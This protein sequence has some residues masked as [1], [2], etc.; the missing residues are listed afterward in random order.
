[1]FAQSRFR[2]LSAFL[3]V[4]ALGACATAAPPPPPNASGVPIADRG[5][6]EQAVR[7]YLRW[8]QD[9]RSIDKLTIR[10]A[11]PQEADGKA[12]DLVVYVRYAISSR[13][14]RRPQTLSWG[15]ERLRLQ[16]TGRGYRV[17]R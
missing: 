5:K 11:K 8:E 12:T 16:T 13:Q 4:L 6:V 15:E 3:L 7:H 1:M 17:L 9:A 10:Y 14:A 2:T